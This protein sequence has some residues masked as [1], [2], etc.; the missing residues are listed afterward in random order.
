MNLFCHLTCSTIVVS[1]DGD[2]DL[3]DL[4]AFQTQYTGPSLGTSDF[5]SADPGGVVGDWRRRDVALDPSGEAGGAE[6][7]EVEEADIIRDLDGY[8]YLLNSYRGL[9]ILDVRNSATP[10]IVG[11]LPLFGTPV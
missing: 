6:P 3:A 9:T 8:L 10:S 11:R 1:N 2:V 4:L 5:L 7:R